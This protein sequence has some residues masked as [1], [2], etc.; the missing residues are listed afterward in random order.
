LAYWKG[1]I[2]TYNFTAES[3][4]IAEIKRISK[5]RPGGTRGQRKIQNL[6]FLKIR[7][8]VVPLNLDI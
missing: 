4:E 5:S 7:F 8:W 1:K 6:G 2:S 3:A